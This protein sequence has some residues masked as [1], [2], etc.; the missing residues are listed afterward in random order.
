MD[1]AQRE[2]LAEE[3][4][5]MV[6]RI[7]FAMRRRFGPVAD[8]D[9][10]RSFALFGLASAIDNFDPSRGAA[11]STYAST[12]V[13]GAVY[14]GLASASW[15]PRRLLRQIAYYRKADEMLAAAAVDPPPADAV[16]SAHRLADRLKE[17]ATAYVASSATP[18][19]DER[20]ATRPEVEEDIDKR[21]FSSA[22]TACVDAM[23]KAQ[24]TLLRRYYFEDAPLNEIASDLGY[25]KSWASRALRAALVDLRKSFRDAP[26]Y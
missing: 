23:P 16:E 22:V 12:R 11:F 1:K 2:R 9:E 13:K 20:L 15:F 19:E 10:M 6:D 26:D 17:L 3:H 5:D 18:A 4:L 24:R 14:D 25:T 8:V 7:V 21:R